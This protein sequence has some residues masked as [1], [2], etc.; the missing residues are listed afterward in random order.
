M[1]TCVHCHP[2]TPAA[3]LALPARV[4]RIIVSGH[5]ETVPWHALQ[6]GDT[7]VVKGNEEFPADVLLLGSSEEEA[8]CFTETAN[9]DGETNLKRRNCVT[10]TASMVGVWKPDM[11]PLQVGDSAHAAASLRGKVRHSAHGPLPAQRP[12]SGLP[13]PSSDDAQPAPQVEF[14]QPNA[15]LYAFTG[16]VILAAGPSV[17][18]PDPT[19]RGASPTFGTR[20][21]LSAEHV[22]LRGCVL[23]N[24]RCARPPPPAVAPPL[25]A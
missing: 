19:P 16:S 12:R 14:E 22:V 10:E 4:Q 13:S 24:C 21:P 25:T 2:S 11:P 3:D 23:R 9:L 8:R 7:V 5:V 20:I 1:P 15:H 6:A 18:S 17:A